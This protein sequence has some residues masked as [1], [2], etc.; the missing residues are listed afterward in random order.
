ML[1]GTVI[2]IT[3]FTGY[4][5]FH[6]L[7]FRMLNSNGVKEIQQ[8]AFNGSRLEELYVILRFKVPH[9]G[10]YSPIFKCIF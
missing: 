8:Y 1:L 9:T 6:P 2:K 3:F 10:Y 7:F 5:L 4:L